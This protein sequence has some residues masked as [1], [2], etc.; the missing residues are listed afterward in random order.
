MV[1]SS[2]ILGRRPVLPSQHRYPEAFRLEKVW[3]SMNFA[4]VTTGDI[5]L[6]CDNVL[7]IACTIAEGARV[8]SVAYDTPAA[9]S[10]RLA[11]VTASDTGRFEALVAHRKS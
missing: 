8:P 6:E 4:A 9:G 10:V 11:A 7:H 1:F 5:D 3:G 2:V